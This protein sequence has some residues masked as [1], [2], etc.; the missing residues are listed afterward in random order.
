MALR[1][2]D[3]T[4]SQ[5]I[6]HKT[7][8]TQPTDTY[9]P[10]PTTT[11]GR[12][13]RREM[14]HRCGTDGILGLWE[15]NSDAIN[16]SLVGRQTPNSELI[17]YTEDSSVHLVP[18]I[19][20]VRILSKSV[21]EILQRVPPVVQGIFRISSTEPAAYLLEASKHFLKRSHRADQYILL[22]KSNLK[23]AVQQCIEAAGHE[24]EISNQKMLIR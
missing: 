23:E 6:Y 22:V 15:N 17:T 3:G 7:K 20:G 24:Y 21:Q 18:E 2:S 1:K 12:R 5:S 4:L 9:M 11:H 14:P 10:L 8:H 13:R 16:L 19:D